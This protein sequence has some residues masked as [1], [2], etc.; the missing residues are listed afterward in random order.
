MNTKIK[1]SLITCAVALLTACG[2]GGGSDTPAVNTAEGMWSGLSS[3]GAAVAIAVLENGEAW[4]L[5]SRSNLPVSAIAGTAS[6]NGTSFSATG[7][8]FVFSSNSVGTGSYTGTVAQKQ[9]IQATSSNGSTIDLSYVSDYDQGVTATD[10]AGSYTLSGR[11]KL[12][13]IT[14]MPLTIDANGNFSSVDG[15]FGA[16]GTATPRASGKAIINM[17][18]T[19]T[20]SCILGNGVVISGV[21]ILDKTTTPHSLFVIALN[22][23][24]TDG[25][26]L[27]GRKN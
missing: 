13:S 4:G 10:I 12:Y 1:L 16:T 7:S 3:N 8:E 23:G 20:G 26:V 24:K 21:A 14:D 27:I 5:A 19:G 6:G 22:S 25:L 9:R 11:T 15:C 2:G 17:T 18:A